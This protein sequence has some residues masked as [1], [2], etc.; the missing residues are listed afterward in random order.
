MNW[1]LMLK[2]ACVAIGS[3]RINAG[4]LTLTPVLISTIIIVV[5]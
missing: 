2:Q 5:A 4:D 1:D 3:R